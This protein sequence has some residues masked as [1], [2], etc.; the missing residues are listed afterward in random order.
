MIVHRDNLLEQNQFE[1]LEFLLFMDLNIGCT[2]LDSGDTRWFNF[3]NVPS[4]NLCNGNIV[5]RESFK[6]VRTCEKIRDSFK[7]I[8]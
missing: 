7:T 2:Q 3:E 8:S 1:N 4:V 5:L 6:I